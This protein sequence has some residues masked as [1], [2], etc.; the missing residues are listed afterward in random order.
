MPSSSQRACQ[1]GSIWAGSY[2]SIAGVRAARVARASGNEV[3]AKPSSVAAVGHGDWWDGSGFWVAQRV[4]CAGDPDKREVGARA[5]YQIRRA[6]HWSDILTEH[7]VLVAHCHSTEITSTG[8][9]IPFRST[10]RGS[11]TR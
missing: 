1:R 11:E 10:E 9:E 4:L 8:L 6:C 3:M 2:L 5:A 7:S